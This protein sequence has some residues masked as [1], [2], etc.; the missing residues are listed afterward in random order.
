MVDI[1]DLKTFYW[2]VRLGGFRKAAEY[3]NT[4]QPAISA[5]IHH[6]EES[7][8]GCLINR[9]RRGPVT[10]SQKGLDL[11]HY[12]ERLLNLHEEML[13]FLS[14]TNTLRGRLRIG[15]AETV[16]HLW[17]NKWLKQL[18]EH[19][20]AI[21]IEISVDVSTVLQDRLLRGELDLALLLGPVNAPTVKNLPLGE[22]PLALV[23][24]T[25]LPIQQDLRSLEPLSRWPI[26]TYMRSTSPHSQ[27]CRLFNN[28]GIAAP[29]IFGNASLV[30]IINMVL[31]GVGIGV[32][33]AVAVTKELAEGK[34]KMLNP[35]CEMPSLSFTAS[36]AR[37]PGDILSAKAAFLAQRV[38]NGV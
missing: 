2:V 8:G 22:V 35:V 33:P 21:D 20:P 13:A 29:R 14:D 9:D 5:R 26:L 36:Y 28:A 12:A 1:R 30:S 4:T 15:V 16:V 6:M 31:D 34:L 37:E 38:A 18:H 19:Y 32:I 25:S 7:F 11:F 23:C 3:L 17:L 10:P 27:V 24:A